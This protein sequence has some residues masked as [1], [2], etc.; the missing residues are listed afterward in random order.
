MP[1]RVSPVRRLN[2]RIWLGDVD[3]LEPGEVSSR[4]GCGGSEALGSTQH[5]LGE[6]LALA[7]GL[8]LQSPE[9]QLLLAHGE[10][11][12]DVQLFPQFGKLADGSS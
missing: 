3:V 2:F 9:H 5:A 12:V 1:D 10:R 7:L 6:E 8:G 4:Q 11:A